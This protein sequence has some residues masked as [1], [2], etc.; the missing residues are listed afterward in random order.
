MVDRRKH[1]QHP[2]G[3]SIQTVNHA[4]QK[5]T[6]LGLAL[7]KRLTEAMDRQIGVNSVVSQGSSF[8]VEFPIVLDSSIAAPAS[9]EDACGPTATS[10]A[11]SLLLY[12]EDNAPNFQ[13]MQRI[14][15]KRPAVRLLPAGTGEAGLQ[16]ARSHFPD[17]I[18]LDLQLPDMNGDLVL[19]HLRRDESTRDIPVVILSADATPRAF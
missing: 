16:L 3:V 10:A 17:L 14:L 19:E 4:Q 18:L 1:E 2:F 11:T 6:G 12:V 8:W 7:C 15:S 13:L 5:G 9:I